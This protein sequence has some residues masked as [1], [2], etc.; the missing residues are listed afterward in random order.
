MNAP[1]RARARDGIHKNKLNPWVLI[2]EV[3]KNEVRLVPGCIEANFLGCID[4]KVYDGISKEKYS[5][6][7][8]K[9][10]D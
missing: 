10:K 4:T 5:T 9:V 1:R 7:W 3:S 2:R 8:E 6:G